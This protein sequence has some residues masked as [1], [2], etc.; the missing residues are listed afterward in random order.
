MSEK[1]VKGFAQKGFVMGGINYQAGDVVEVTA[2]KF[3]ELSDKNVKLL[4][5]TKPVKKSVS[6]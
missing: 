2:E 6:K 4:G 3:D 5:K 1:L